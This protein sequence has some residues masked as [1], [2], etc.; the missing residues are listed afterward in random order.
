[1]KSPTS[2]LLFASAALLASALH[3]QAPVV[4]NEFNYDDSGSDNYEFV[5]L[6]ANVTTDISGWTLN[7]EDGTS[8]STSNGSITI[9]AGT[10]LNAGEFYLISSDLDPAVYTID[11][12]ANGINLENGA[13]G[14][15]IS[16]ANGVVV[17]SVLWEVADW[18]NPIP[19]WIEGTG[20]YG[21]IQLHENARFNSASRSRDGQD[22]DV[23]GCDF[24]V[25]EWSP[26]A[27]NNGGYAG[28]SYVD[29]FDGAVGDT[30]DFLYSF[31]PG[32]TVDP[33]GLDI[34]RP[35]SPQGGL[36]SLWS[37]TAGGNSNW[38]GG[39][40]SAD[41][42]VECYVH[43]AGIDATGFDADDGES[44]VI[45][46]AGTADSFG[47]L[48]D[49]GGYLQHINCANQSGHTGIAWMQTRTAINSD[50]FLVD[51]NDG[52]GD[53]TILAQIPIVTGSNDGWQ[54]LRLSVVDGNIRANFGGTYGRDDGQVF[55]GTVSAPCV[56]GVYFTHRECLSVN[57]VMNALVID[58]LRINAATAL[59]YG[60]GCGGLTLSAASDPYVSSTAS[61]PFTLRTDGLDANAVGHLGFIGTAQSAL[62]LD[63]DGMPGC[64]SNANVGVA[65]FSVVPPGSTSVTWTAFA[66]PVN[67]ALSGFNVYC[68]S[69]VFG[70][71]LN[72]AFG[73]GTLTSNGV[74]CT[75]G[76]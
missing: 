9:P 70:T 33:A 8:S 45:G 59:S 34:P 73:L 6:Y 60:Q 51:L 61:N 15:Y 71:N 63:S 1:M 42:V 75:I 11:L 14:L 18:S 3:A 19:T 67:T 29:E 32:T 72:S 74:A 66:I 56:G 68:Q 52:G 36:A 13:D 4:I 10:I 2:P 37:D 44:W 76:Y 48:P 16:D 21:A 53:F 25:K 38:Y 57:A 35:P 64:F 69:A 20:I 50:L 40:P 24:I 58:S 30:V 46:V 5:E 27:S 12:S 41:G 49:V 62:P 47:E 54:R 23:N 31:V 55:T 22:T 39:S 43:L 65:T 26:G 7:G 28:D 17:D